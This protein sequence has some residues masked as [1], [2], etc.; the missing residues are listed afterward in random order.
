LVL[1]I[2]TTVLVLVTFAFTTLVDEPATAVALMVILLLSIGLTW[3]GS[4]PAMR[5][6]VRP[7]PATLEIAVKNHPGSRESPTFNTLR[8][9]TMETARDH[10]HA[11]G[12]S[13]SS[14]C[15]TSGFSST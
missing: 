6:P 11:G 1:A 4:A 3:D 15:P 14:F 9:S 8:L 13:S 12:R 10:H 2:V 5:A 7:E